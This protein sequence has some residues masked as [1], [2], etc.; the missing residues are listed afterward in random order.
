MVGGDD[1]YLVGIFH[2]VILEKRDVFEIT[3]NRHYVCLI[4][5]MS[6]EECNR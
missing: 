6:D 2:F 1:W 4:L 3:L 5:S